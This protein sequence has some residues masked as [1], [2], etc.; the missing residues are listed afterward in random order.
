MR[1][2]CPMP[3]SRRRPRLNSQYHV[4]KRVNKEIKMASRCFWDSQNQ[5]LGFNNSKCTNAVNHIT[6]K[7]PY[8]FKKI[9]TN[10]SFESAWSM[11][12]S[13]SGDCVVT[14]YCN[15][16]SFFAWSTVWFKSLN[17]L[18]GDNRRE[19][20]SA[21]PFESGATIEAAAEFSAHKLKE[22]T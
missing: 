5:Y 9:T 21:I 3:G 6:N 19:A 20:T 11:V 18:R 2:R 1:H 4:N 16:A 8:M 13:R 14:A 10:S 15:V 17:G 7:R 22:I 12:G